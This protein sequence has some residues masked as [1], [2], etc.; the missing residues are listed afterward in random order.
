[1]ENEKEIRIS[2][3]RKFGIAA[4]ASQVALFGGLIAGYELYLGIAVESGLTLFG[5]IYRIVNSLSRLAVY[6][7]MAVLTVRTVS[8]YWIQEL[9]GEIRDRI[10]KLLILTLI[11]RF[12]VELIL[13]AVYALQTY[14][15]AA[16]RL[17]SIAGSLLSADVLIP[18]IAALFMKLLVGKP[19]GSRR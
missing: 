4:A 14:E 18:V 8:G 13:G 19:R 10:G 7:M 11:L 16:D 1:M 9:D 2:K 15:T 5:Q 17:R 3:L 6:V 12:G